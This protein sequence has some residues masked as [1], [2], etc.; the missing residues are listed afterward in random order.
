MNPNFNPKV[1][2]CVVTYNQEKYI[3]ECLKSIVEQDVNFDFEVLVADDCSTDNTR[4]IV[5]EFS[6]KYPHIIKPILRVKNVGALTNYLGVHKSARGAYVAHIDGDDLML[7]GKLQKQ[8]DFLDLNPDFSVVWHRV[9][10]FD[11]K[12]GFFPGNG[13]DYSFFPA[14]VVTLSHALRLGSV[15]A[16]SS[17]MYRRDAR[18]THEADFPI[19]DLFFTWEYLCSGKGKMLD[20]VLGAYRVAAHGSIMTSLNMRK[21]NAHHASYYLRLLPGQRKN[22]FVFAILNFLIDLKNRRPTRRDFAKLMRESRCLVSPLVVF[23]SFLQ[24]RQLVSH[25]LVYERHE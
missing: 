1:T 21:I 6:A 22:I 9:D 10:L 13:Y 5:R 4:E 20:D 19:I 23:R 15:G 3:R 17:C 18:K 25:P 7:P 24:I 2:V 16:H 11:D 14:G 8:A 12:G